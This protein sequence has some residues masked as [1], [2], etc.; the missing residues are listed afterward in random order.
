MKAMDRIIRASQRRARL[1]GLARHRFVAALVVIGCL[2]APR[3]A[4]EAGGGVGTRAA[5]GRPAQATGADDWLQG[6]ITVGPFTNISRHPADDWLSDGIAATVT[7]DLTALGLSV[8]GPGDGEAHA[9]WAVVG[10]YQRLGDRLRITAR[11]VDVAT[12]SVRHAIRVD[13]AVD[14]IFILQDRIVAELTAA[15]GATPLASPRDVTGGIVLPEPAREPP[16]V[17]G[18]ERPALDRGTDAGGFGIATDAGFLTG[19]PSVRPVRTTQPPRIDGRL[20][21]PVWRDA[22]RITELVQQTPLDGAPATE[23]TEVYLAYDAQ[24]VYVG[25]YAH[26][27]D[28]TLIRANRSDRDQT[29][30]DDTIAIYLDPF[31]D[32]QRAYV[33]SVNGYGVQSDAVLDSQSTRHGDGVGRGRWWRWWRRPPPRQR[34]RQHGQHAPRGDGCFD[35]GGL[36]GGAARRHLLGRALRLRRRA[37]RGW[38][39]GRK[40]RSR[41]R[42]YGIRRVGLARSTA[43]GSRSRARLRAGRR[44]TSGRGSPATSPA[45]CRRWVCLM[46]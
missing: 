14:E 43:G 20:D 31:L 41:S 33:F 19:R 3:A 9:R 7:A 12:G 4:V 22:T 45:F 29:F 23:A 38:V 16:S 32:Q 2:V 13:G 36:R 27:S 6:A 28:P 18:G 8:V 40:W 44:P 42:A 1:N 10:G 25:V 35:G 26:Y 46:E 17:I 15:F 5:A 30:S 34:R 39:D 21:D 24:N 37:R 11:L